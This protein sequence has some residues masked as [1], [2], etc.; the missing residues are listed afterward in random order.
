MSETESYFVVFETAVGPYKGTMTCSDHK[1]EAALNNY[2]KKPMQDSNYLG[3]VVGQVYNVVAKG[4]TQEEAQAICSSPESKTA[5]LL[6]RLS[7][8]AA[9]SEHMTKNP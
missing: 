4:V 2:L 6:G 5:G 9:V 7:E 3:M 1:S 8:A